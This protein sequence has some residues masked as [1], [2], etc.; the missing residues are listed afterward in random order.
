MANDS[1][2]Y[3]ALINR[4]VFFK[5]F[6]FSKNEFVPAGQS[7]AQ[8][9]DHVI[10]IDDLLMVYQI[11]ERSRPD[12]SAEAEEK[13]FKK[14]VLGE[15]TA[16]VRKTLDYLASEVEIEIENQR[17]HRFNLASQPTAYPIKLVIYVPGSR[18]P[19]SCLSKKFHISSS[20]GLIHILALNDYITI[21]ETLITPAE[22]VE[23][24]LFREAIINKW[25]EVA[26]PEENALIGHY[27][28]G[29]GDPPSTD[30]LKNFDDFINEIESFDLFHMLSL[31]GDRIDTIQSENDYYAI[32][33]EFA[34]LMRGEL[35]AVKERIEYCLD[36]IKRDEFNFPTRMLS[37]R[38]K[39]GF[40]FL[41]LLKDRFDHKELL[42]KKYSEMAKYDMKVDKQIGVSFIDYY[43][44]KG[45]YA[46]WML[47]EH[48][49]EYN[50]EFESEIKEFDIFKPLSEP[51][52]RSRYKFENH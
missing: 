42:L 1:E 23:Y 11:K 49:W 3:L 10:W 40:L 8:F 28:H 46:N 52:G 32:L 19:E 38:T 33:A 4:N 44:G 27:L 48:P 43:G 45:F 14:K 9:A 26:L 51:K 25:P 47:I 2:K 22:I 20:V 24:F 39:C 6:S 18:L 7:E 5:E 41:P 21:C 13:W 16:Q 29:G 36:L 12:G 15:A 37:T 17:G 30:F 31:I 34:K 50:G 35:A